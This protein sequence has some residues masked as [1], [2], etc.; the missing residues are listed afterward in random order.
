MLL[1]LLCLPAGAAQQPTSQQ[2]LEQCEIAR[3]KSQHARLR[4][5]SQQLLG[6]AQQQ[7]DQRLKAYA[8][9]YSGQ[10]DLFDGRGKAALPTLNQ[11]LE[12]ANAIDADSVRAAVM[13]NLGIYYATVETNPFLAQQ[14]FLRAI[15][16]AH[17]AGYETLRLRVTGN[18]LVLTHTGTDTATV[19]RAREIYD[20]GVKHNNQEMTYMGTF[21]LAQI[22]QHAKRYDQAIAHIKEALA[23]YEQYP[24]DDIAYVYT[25]YSQVLTAMGQLPQAMQQAQHAVKYAHDLNQVR[26]LP[27]TYL[28]L[29]RVL[30]AQG[31]HSESNI[32][33]QRA[34]DAADSG[35]NRTMVIDCEQ[36]LAE[37]LTD[38]GRPAEAHPHLLRAYEAQKALD[39]VNYE[40]IEH[41]QQVMLAMEQ[42]E[43]Q[44]QLSAIEAKNQHRVAI[45]LAVVV[46]LLLALLVVLVTSGR[47][48]RKLYR[49]IVAQNSQAV[50]KQQE[51]QQ[52]LA[53]LTSEQQ[54]LQTAKPAKPRI[55]QDKGA[56]IYDQLCQLMEQERVWA[57]PQL[58]RERLTEML[59]TNRTYLSAIV[60]EKSGMSLVQF[61]NS[62]RITEAVRILSDRNS[63]NVPIKQLYQ[64]LG[65][66]SPTTFYKLFQ[67]QVGITPSVY[68][69][70]VLAQQPEPDN[71]DD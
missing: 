36:L 27:D 35:N 10:A 15:R 39:S 13:N 23:I 47:K 69:R 17:T 30:R 5:L 6:M 60:K 18:L 20:Y 70:Q 43:K 25:L 67:Q 14:F 34:L 22:A 49:N 62:Y 61:I 32:W 1:A 48:R 28:Q 58:G 12:L 2:V 38:M 44:A 41:E 29:A 24:Y 63:I 37:N 9:L 65:F 53:K 42:K 45:A 19:A 26:V 11:A 31:K 57:D 7:G 56:E 55:A 51:L 66:S 3:D 54:E 4:S 46:L 68:R 40:R 8:L 16:H 50:A 52:R 59:G 64:S 71:D 33:A 21:F